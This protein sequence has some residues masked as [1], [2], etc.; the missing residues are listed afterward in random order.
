MSRFA[1]LLLLFF[2][3]STPAFAFHCG[4]KLV[5]EGDTRGQVRSKCGEP[6]E[7]EVR[8]ILRRPVAWVG[9][10]PVFVGSDFV[11]IPVEFWTYNFGPNKLMRRLRFEGGT[12]VEIETLTHGYIET[13]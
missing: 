8:S 12:L 11:E 6:S 10:S 13:R 3:A 1:A 9:G 7:I 5:H 4:G 2:M